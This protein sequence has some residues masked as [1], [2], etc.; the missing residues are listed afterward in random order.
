M[1][2]SRT[3][4]EIDGDFS[5]KSH[6]FPTPCILRPRSRSSP[7]NWVSALDVKKL[8]WRDIGPA[9]KFDDIFNPVDTMHQRDRRTD[10]QTDGHTP[11]DSKDRA[12]A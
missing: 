12:Y 7:W 9:K 10:G 4:S 3:D 11:G 6:N 1:G 5:Q 8:E 2:L